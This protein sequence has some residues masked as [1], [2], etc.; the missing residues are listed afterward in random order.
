MW[1]CNNCGKQVSDNTK[2]CTFCGTSRTY[3]AQ[4]QP[5]PAQPMP[6]QPI[7][8]A[9]QPSEPVISQYAPAAIKRYQDSYRVAR[10]INGI[11]RGI[12]L[13]G[14]FLSLLVIAAVILAVRQER[15]PASIL[16]TS[17]GTGILVVVILLCFWIIGIFIAASGQS[18]KAQIDDVV[19][20]S[21]FLNDEQRAEAM[22]L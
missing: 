7:F 11:G 18:L 1:S 20:R 8:A 17:I 16:V 4:P 10:R 19:Y 15:I 13:F 5:M 2:F 9:S 14:V 3:P 21:P 12:K 6:A 22:S